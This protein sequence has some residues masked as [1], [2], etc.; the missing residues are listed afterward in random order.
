L[1]TYIDLETK[2]ITTVQKSHDDSLVS[3]EKLDPAIDAG[4]FT[5]S[6][7]GSI[8]ASERAANVQFT[9]MPWNGG[10]NAAETIIDRVS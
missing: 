8:D 4:V 2:L 10:A 7:L 6:A 9:F 1:K 3:I 5:R